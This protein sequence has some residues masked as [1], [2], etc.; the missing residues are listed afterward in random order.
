MSDHDCA[1]V[2]DTVRA[3][4]RWDP[5]RFKHA[6]T[7]GLITMRMWLDEE[8]WDELE[9]GARL[10]YCAL[11]ARPDRQ[12]ANASALAEARSADSQQ[13]VVGGTTQESDR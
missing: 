9:K 2:S 12:K 1:A 6:A 13:R 7:C 11:L 5:I 3:D 10:L 8:N 4:V